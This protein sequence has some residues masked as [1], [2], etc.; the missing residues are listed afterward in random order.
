MHPLWNDYL[1]GRPPLWRPSPDLIVPIGETLPDVPIIPP[2]R[3]HGK[4][5]M[6][7]A[8]LIAAATLPRYEDR[9]DSGR[10]A[11]TVRRASAWVS[12]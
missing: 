8:D 7:L 12:A 11:M 3:S 1:V 2:E 10:L 6:A 9:P 5:G 4:S